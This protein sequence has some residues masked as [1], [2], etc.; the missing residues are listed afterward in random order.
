MKNFKKLL[1]LALAFVLVLSL[2][3]CGPEEDPDEDAEATVA[4]YKNG[5][6]DVQLGNYYIKYNVTQ[7][8]IKEDEEGDPVADENGTYIQEEKTTTYVEVGYQGLYLK[9]TDGGE[10]FQFDTAA[11]PCFSVVSQSDPRGLFSS[12]AQFTGNTD[13]LSELGKETV[14]GLE[15]THY[16]YKSG[17]Y[18]YHMYVNDEY[19]V[20][21]KYVNEGTM[22]VELKNMEVLELS[23]GTINADGGYDFAEFQAK[24][25]TPAPATE[26]PEA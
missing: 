25:V 5:I 8:V 24:V 6:T 9:S 3:A 12:F 16:Q 26:A 1:V 13:K 7:L 23:F 4:P 22:N 11:T 17:L 20:T 15:T 2:A 21:L 14:A 19:Q 18:N 10:T